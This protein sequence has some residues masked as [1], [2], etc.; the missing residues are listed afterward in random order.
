MAQSAAV[1]ALGFCKRST[2][3]R[4]DGRADRGTAVVCCGAGYPVTACGFSAGRGR[5]RG[6]IE[7][8][9]RRW[10]R[11]W[12]EA[13]G[14]AAARYGAGEGNRTLVVSLGNIRSQPKTVC[15]I[16]R[17]DQT[18]RV[19]C[20]RFVGSACNLQKLERVKGIE[21]SSLAWEANAL[22]LSYTRNVDLNTVSEWQ[23][24]AQSA[25]MPAT[26]DTILSA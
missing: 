22:P 3:R 26:G 10:A 9:R 21:P 16:K 8:C 17:L 19:F 20:R 23:L 25:F 12:R 4:A 14:A 13:Y 1:L 15:I 24:Q 18:F 7:P 11:L 2:G 6:W 5:A